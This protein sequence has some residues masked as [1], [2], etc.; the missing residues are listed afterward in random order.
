MRRGRRAKI[1]HGHAS[2]PLLIRTQQMMPSNAFTNSK[3][4]VTGKD[5]SSLDSELS[6]PGELWFIRKGNE[7]YPAMLNSTPSTS[8]LICHTGKILMSSTLF[9]TYATM[10]P[11]ILHPKKK[12]CSIGMLLLCSSPC[13]KQHL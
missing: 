5:S 12:G 2:T 4:E 8:L 7:M 3:Q 11:G 1:S 6:E 10:L 13:F 9:K